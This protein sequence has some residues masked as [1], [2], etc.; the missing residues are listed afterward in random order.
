MGR[1]ILAEDDELVGQIVVDR[2]VAAGHAVGWLRDGKEALDAMRFRPPDLVIL[3][4]RMPTMNGGLVLRKMRGT[5]ELSMIPVLMLTAVDGEQDKDIAY[6]E[7]A[8]DY[9]T[10]PFNPDLLVARAESLMRGH[11]RRTSGD[12]NPG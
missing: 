6:Y 11:I 8:D 5:W 1:I 2:F 10:K 7:G 4:Q 12:L 9:M 3:D